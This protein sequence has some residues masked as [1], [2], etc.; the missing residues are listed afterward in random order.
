MKDGKGISAL[1]RAEER[2]MRVI[3]SLEEY[4]EHVPPAVYAAAEK[5][6]SQAL[7]D[8]CKPHDPMIISGWT[9]ETYAIEYRCPPEKAGDIMNLIVEQTA[10]EELRERMEDLEED[11]ELIHSAFMLGG[12]NEGAFVIA[13]P[14][15]KWWAAESLE[16]LVGEGKLIDYTSGNDSCP[17][18]GAELMDG[19]TL[20]IHTG[21]P[22]PDHHTR[23]DGCDPRF[24]VYVFDVDKDPDRGEPVWLGENE[25]AAGGEVE[26]LIR[27]HGGVRREMRLMGP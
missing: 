19:L 6:F 10:Y 9:L 24:V 22:N 17:S 26:R 12:P 18:L 25:V 8:P 15:L 7:T 2:H 11:T 3:A 13:K 1:S 14:P 23:H 16:K 27:A 5:L 20:Q 4:R 21:H